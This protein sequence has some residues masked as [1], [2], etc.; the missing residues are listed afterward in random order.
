MTRILFI[1][2]AVVATALPAHA[3]DLQTRRMLS[4][5]ESAP[6]KGIGR[7]NV[8]NGRQTGMCT[9]T[10]VAPDLVLTAAHCVI[11][12]ATGEVFQPGNIHFVAGWRLGQMV[13]HRLA[14]AIAVHPEYVHGDRLEPAQ[15]AHDLA[16]IRLQGD[17]ADDAAMSFPVGKP[18]SASEPLTV[19]SYRQDRPHALTRQ[20]QCV[21]LG[22]RDG[23]LALD[24]PITFG[25]SGSPVFRVG[26]GVP[27]VVAVISAMGGIG[28]EDVAFAAPVAGAMATLLPL[29]SPTP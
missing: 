22:A 12:P 11:D 14:G 15:V 28:G 3:L 4:A 23:A 2:L 10:L 17:I 1:V 6:W 13:A 19:V 16:V 5:E 20:G 7:V 18:R 21:L 24:C 29:L 9:G 26:D 8:E 27:Q 25:V